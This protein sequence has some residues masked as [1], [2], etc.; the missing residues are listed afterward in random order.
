MSSSWLWGKGS[1]DSSHC[2]KQED[3]T[4]LYSPN[5]VY[6]NTNANCTCLASRSLCLTWLVSCSGLVQKA[7]TWS[8]T[9]FWQADFSI[10]KFLENAMSGLVYRQYDTFLFRFIAHPILKR[11][12]YILLI[13]ILVHLC[14]TEMVGKRAVFIYWK[15]AGILNKIDLCCVP[16]HFDI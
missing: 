12:T 1:V 4:F 9:I 3:D 13:R 10:R 11:A 14:K 2:C 7:E 5:P 8:Y 6:H 16:Q 15:Y